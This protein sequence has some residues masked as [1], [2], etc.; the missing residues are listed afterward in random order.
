MSI[1][2]KRAF[3]PPSYSTGRDEVGD[4]TSH[5]S[6]SSANK[7]YAKEHDGL[8]FATSDLLM[9]T[10]GFCEQFWE[11]GPLRQAPGLATPLRHLARGFPRALPAITSSE[12]AQPTPQ[13]FDLRSITAIVSASVQAALAAFR[14]DITS[15]IRAAIIAGIAEVQME[16][17]AP[18]NLRTSHNRAVI[19]PR[20][21][22]MDID[23]HIPSQ[24]LVHTQTPIPTS[25]PPVPRVS[26]FTAVVDVQEKMKTF[27]QDPEAK[28]TCPAQSQL[29]Y[30]SCARIDTLVAIMGTGSGKS[31][32]FEL[33]PSYEDKRSVVVHAFKSMT[34][35]SERRAGEKGLRWHHWTASEPDVGDARLIILAVESFIT[36]AFQSYVFMSHQTEHNIDNANRFLNANEGLIGRCVFDE[37]HNI[38]ASKSYRPAF[39]QLYNGYKNPIPRYYLTATLPPCLETQFLAACGLPPTTTIIRAPTNRVEHSFSI[40]TIDGKSDLEDVT[41]NL[42]RLVEVTCFQPVSRGIIYTTSIGAAHRVAQNLDVVSYTSDDFE[43]SRI[44]S[45]DIWRKGAVKWIVATSGFI[46]GVDYPRVDCIIFMNLPRGMFDFVQGSGRGGRG[47]SPAK[48]YVVKTSRSNLALRDSQAQIL[49]YQ[50]FQDWKNNTSQCRRHHISL[51]MDGILVKCLELPGA[52]KCDI[53]DPRSIQ[54]QLAKE[55]VRNSLERLDGTKYGAEGRIHAVEMDTDLEAQHLIAPLSEFIPSEVAMHPQNLRRDLPSVANMLT[56]AQI[57]ILQERKREY[58]NRCSFVLSCVL[59]RCGENG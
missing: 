33:P 13:P 50:Q 42:A 37:A 10:Y 27:F 36:P 41:A 19:A 6:S 34:A 21:H 47:G 2:I 5:H 29:L 16:Q 48:I 22:A 44:H 45:V 35:E 28:F 8:D 40:T 20:E 15:D 11:A 18:E 59:R 3:I 58:M 31:L 25:I 52:Q 57:R 14:V 54:I 24:G 12:N 32:A 38:L 17:Q 51:C 55:A 39:T 1:A 49:C 46:H 26:S 9:D 30:A 7:I 23:I 43:E 53:C 4:R 56:A